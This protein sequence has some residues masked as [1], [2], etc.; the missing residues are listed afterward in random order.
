MPASLQA[1]LEA[2]RRRWRSLAVAGGFALCFAAVTTACLI[3]FHMDRIVALTT[4]GRFAW[5]IVLLTV[6][7]VSALF[8]VLV[9]IRRPLADETLAA[10]VER[11]YPAL[12]ERLLS[13]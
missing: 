2:A 12:N 1:K 7:G 4:P 9:P 10:D 6:L 8:F 3:S 5:L 11:A 13:T